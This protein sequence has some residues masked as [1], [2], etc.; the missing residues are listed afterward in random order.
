M[1]NNRVPPTSTASIP[2]V[3][4]NVSDDNDDIDDNGDNEGD[5]DDDDDDSNYYED[6]VD[7]NSHESNDV[8]DNGD[9]DYEGKR[10]SMTV[11][12]DISSRSELV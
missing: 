11:R 12:D 6:F 3:Q 4:G 5:T 2:E 7:N 1:P 10:I 8:D 9:D